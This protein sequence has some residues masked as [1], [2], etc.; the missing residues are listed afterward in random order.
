[1]HPHFTDLILYSSS[2]LWKNTKAPLCINPSGHKY[3]PIN[4]QQ[5]ATLH[6]LFMSSTCFGWFLHPSSRAHTTV[7]TASGSCQS[8]T[9][10]CCYR[11]RVGT[12]EHPS[13]GAHSTV[14][15]VSGTCQTV[16]VTC[17]YRGKVGEQVAV[18]VWQVADA[19][20][21]GVCAP[22]DGWRYHPKYVE[23]FTDRNK[24]C[25]VAFCWIYVGIYIFILQDH[26]K[27]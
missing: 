21:A 23:Q 18:T 2:C 27:Y 10:T 26:T 9:A 6:S 20:D 11:G 13:S 14:S 19:V 1:M 24:L 4:I 16:T 3:I 25:N 7:S 17:R 22:D 15:T 12:A 8:V 5:D